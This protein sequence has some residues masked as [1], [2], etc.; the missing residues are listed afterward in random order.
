V[1]PAAPA[2]LIFRSFR[3]AAESGDRVSGGLS[4][5]RVGGPKIAMGRAAEMHTAARQIRSSADQLH[6]MRA[7]VASC[8]NACGF[9]A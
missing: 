4:I 3:I 8:F 2:G 9:L 5:S 1:I 6:A 7:V